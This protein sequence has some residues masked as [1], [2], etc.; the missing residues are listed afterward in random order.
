MCIYGSVQLI[1]LPFST[2]LRV[3]SKVVSATPECPRYVFSCRTEGGWDATHV[4]QRQFF[5]QLC[6]PSNKSRP[7]GAHAGH[8]WA[9]GCICGL[10][11]GFS[12]HNN[13]VYPFAAQPL[14]LRISFCRQQKH[15]RV[16]IKASVGLAF[17]ASGTM[18]DSSKSPW[19]PSRQRGSDL[20]LLFCR[21]Y[22]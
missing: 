20:Q 12:S 1:S 9:Q 2:K 6:P 21:F 17:A 13:S 19:H 18:S 15:R 3:V 5:L 4:L 8:W 10:A 16:S 11:W 7:L 22:A 14:A